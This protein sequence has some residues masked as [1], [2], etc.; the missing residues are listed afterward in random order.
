MYQV[1]FRDLPIINDGHVYKIDRHGEVKWDIGSKVVHKGSFETSVKVCCDGR[2]VS[3]EGNVGRFGRQDNLFGYSVV[4]CVLIANKLLALFGLPPFSDASPMPI[5]GKGHGFARVGESDAEGRQSSKG[6]SFGRDPDS[7]VGV[8]DAYFKADSDKGF[9]A[10]ASVITRVDLTY[11]WA[12]GSP[13]NASQFC[14][15]LAGFKSRQAE[16]K[17]YQTSGVSW[18]EGSKYWYAKVYDKAADYIRHLSQDNSLH[19]SRLYEFI[20]QSGTVRHEIS[21]KSRYLKQHNLWRFTQWDDDMQAKVY[22]LFSDVIEGQANVDSFLEIPGRAGELAVAWRDGADLK[23]RLAKNTFYR[24]R[25]ELLKYNIDIAVRSNVE[26]LKTKVNVIDL[27]S[28]S[29]PSWY[30]LPP[31]DLVVFAPLQDEEVQI[32]VAKLRMA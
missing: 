8:K 32:P 29:I 17:S 15:Y 28:L 22:A 16:P 11:N 18:G 6:T 14:R 20:L 30:Y 19:D 27:A 10:V 1:H 3:I 25:R 12:T 31:V 5:I 13:G 23:K 21:L 26:R 2:R 4:D 7:Q 9:Q 24:Y